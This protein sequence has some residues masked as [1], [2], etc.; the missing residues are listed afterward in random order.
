MQKFIKKRFYLCITFVMSMLMMPAWSA[1]I[2]EI[3]YMTNEVFLSQS[4]ESVTPDV[5]TIWLKGTL[6]IEVSETLGHDY[7]ALRIR[8]W[9]KDGRSAWILDEIGRDKPITMGFVIEGQQLISV[10]VL[11][12]RESRG[13]EILLPSFTRQFDGAQLA[14][15]HQLDR[16]IDG[17]SGAT[18]SVNAARKL[19]AVALQLDKHA[20]KMESDR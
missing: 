4:F 19:A 13:D 5:K 2:K 17:I 14:N 1:G 11:V 20:M 18:L 10:R 16:H 6:K 7:P 12:F 8:Y 15:T 3:V 9:L